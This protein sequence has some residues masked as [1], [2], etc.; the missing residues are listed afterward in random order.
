MNRKVRTAKLFNSGNYYW[1]SRS[2]DEQVRYRENVAADYGA[3][4][5]QKCELTAQRTRGFR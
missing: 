3:I 1:H 5:S 4:G 2:E